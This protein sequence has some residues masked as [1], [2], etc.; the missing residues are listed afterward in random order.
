MTA[1]RLDLARMHGHFRFNS[2]FVESASA[3]SFP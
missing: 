2:D 1:A 3:H